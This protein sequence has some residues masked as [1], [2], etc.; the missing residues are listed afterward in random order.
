MCN[1]LIKSVRCGESVDMIYMSSG[2]VISKRRVKVLQVNEDYFRTYCYL[3]RSKRTFRVDNVLAL[4]P[5]IKKE[6]MVI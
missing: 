4:V 5:V 3:R 6:G 2:G 1:Q